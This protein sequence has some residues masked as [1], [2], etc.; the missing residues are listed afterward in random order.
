MDVKDKR[1]LL[2]IFDDD[3]D[4]MAAVGHLRESQVEVFDC[5]TPF[6]IHGMDDA[7]GIKRSRLPIVT[8]FAGLAGVS[9]AL[10]VQYWISA[11][12]WPVNVGGKS[13]NSFP[14]FIPVAFELTVLF[15]ALFTVLAFILRS[16]L[17]PI[18]KPA[19]AHKRQTDD[20][21]VLAIEAKDAAL[22]EEMIRGILSKHHASEI[23]F[24]EGSTW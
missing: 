6:P 23:H 19:I 9:L 10:G 1:F 17:C 16:K 7:M 3:H 8:F 12:D 18:T 22:N 4:I 14:A 13:F 15:G 20:K 2:G 21:F 5:Y 11:V 24:S